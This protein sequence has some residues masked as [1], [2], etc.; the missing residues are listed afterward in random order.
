[1]NG[2]PK[3]QSPSNARTAHASRSSCSS[4]SWRPEAMLC[5]RCYRRLKAAGRRTRLRFGYGDLENMNNGTLSRA[6]I[7][8]S[9]R[10]MQALCGFAGRREPDCASDCLVSEPRNCSGSG[11]RTQAGGNR[12]SLESAA[13][14]HLARMSRVV[15]DGSRCQRHKR[16][17]QRV[18]D[19]GRGSAT[20]RGYGG[21]W[22]RP[23]RGSLP[24]ILSA[25]AG[26]RRVRSTI[27]YRIAAAM[28]CSGMRVCG[29]RN[30]SLSFE[31]DCKAGWKMG[32][33]VQ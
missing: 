2:E 1:M 30:A 24:C 14:L 10:A 27:E 21:R 32:T 22:L 16:Q 26:N 19:A 13:S 15:K 31:K 8:R 6:A 12:E 17:E 4:A 23:A 5:D 25:S 18:Y 11:S 28:T 29:L 3:M 7:K 9:K 33:L 20:Q